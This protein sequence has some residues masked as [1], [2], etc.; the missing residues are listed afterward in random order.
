MVN[1]AIYLIGYNILTMITYLD[2]RGNE[3]NHI[4]NK[5]NKVTFN[6]T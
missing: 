5:F 2:Q 3:L 1:W 6:S 4:G